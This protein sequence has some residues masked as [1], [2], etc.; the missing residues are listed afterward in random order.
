MDLET[1]GFWLIMPENLPGY[2]AAEAGLR[3][4]TGKRAL[5][6]NSNGCWNAQLEALLSVL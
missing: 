2:I 1:L 3:L 6:F 5:A 4:C